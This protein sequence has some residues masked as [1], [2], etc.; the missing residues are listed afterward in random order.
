VSRFADVARVEITQ[1]LISSEYSADWSHTLLVVL[2]N[3]RVLDICETHEPSNPNMLPERQR[4]VLYAS[5]RQLTDLA[6]ELAGILGVETT[7]RPEDLRRI[8]LTQATQPALWVAASEFGCGARH[9]APLRPAASR[10]W[11]SARGFLA[12][13]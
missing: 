11:G 7:V 8:W 13:L 10:E 5:R 3:K 9:A 4:A 2:K 6:Q 12:G 1:T